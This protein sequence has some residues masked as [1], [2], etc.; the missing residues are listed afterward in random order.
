MTNVPETPVNFLLVDDLEENLISLEALL[1]REGLSFLKAPSGEAALELLLRND[2]ALALL[3]VQMPGM[4]GFELAELMRGSERTRHIPIIFLT[5]GSTDG[6]RRFRGYEAGA[7][8]FIQ[9][10][11]EPDI[12]R[13]KANVFFDLY[14]Q[15]QQIAAQRDALEAQTETLKRLEEVARRQL[16]QE[17]ETA[18]LREQFIAVLGHDLRNPVAAIGGAANILRKQP[19]TEKALKILDLMEGSVARMVGLIDDVMDLARTRLG[20]GIALN[21]RRIPLGP[22]LHQVVEELQAAHPDREIDCVFDLRDPVCVDSGR[23]GQLVSNLLTNAL[24]YG[25]PQRPVRVEA[26]LGDEHL[27]LSVI[28]SGPPISEA[29]MERLFQPF[30]RGDGQSEQRGLG[31]GLHIACEIAKAHGG[32][33]DADSSAGETRFTLT[34]PIASEEPTT[35]RAAEYTDRKIGRGDRICAHEARER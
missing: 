19:Q 4:D 16:V 24:L 14:C 31:L 11:I 6:Q 30:V 32:Q 15:R 33:L 34:L 25:D 28:N 9:K 20:S 7:V 23:I 5:A 13:S 8:D 22:V 26:A 29:A 27:I 35:N 17:Q 10:P 3:D 1:R 12:L 2:V 18:R 21:R